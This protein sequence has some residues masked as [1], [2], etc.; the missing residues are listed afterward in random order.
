MECTVCGKRVTRETGVPVDDEGIVCANMECAVSYF[1]VSRKQYV[2]TC[3]RCHCE[4]EVNPHQL[5]GQLSS[6]HYCSA[7]LVALCC[8]AR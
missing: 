3:E 1:E 2:Q 6:S 4:Y 5:E 7:C 8:P